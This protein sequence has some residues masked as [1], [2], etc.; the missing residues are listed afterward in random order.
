MNNKATYKRVKI[1][2]FVVLIFVGIN[3]LIIFAHIHQWGSNPIDKSRLLFI[4]AAIWAM[5]LVCTPRFKIIIDDK[6]V[7]LFKVNWWMIL[8]IVGFY[9]LVIF[10]Y[11]NQISGSSRAISKTGFMI[12]TIVWILVLFL[13]GRFKVIIN[14]YN[15][16]FSHKGPDFWSPT[17]IQIVDV[18]NVSVKQIGLK[19][20]SGKW[21]DNYIIDFVKKNVC[22][23]MKNGKVYQIAIKDAERI[24]EEIEKRM[25]NFN[26]KIS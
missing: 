21:I 2:W 9:V 22:V 4:S 17:K 1:N 14:H 6:S 25:L 5:F 13:A 20:V 11:I 7:K 26:D 19:K 15:A 3:V 23:Q 16:N 12:M 18:K 8:I 10:G 24:K